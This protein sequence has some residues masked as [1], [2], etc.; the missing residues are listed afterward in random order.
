MKWEGLKR[1]KIFLSRK[2]KG[3]TKYLCNRRHFE[4][5][6]PFLDFCYSQTEYIEGK[7]W[8]CPTSHSWQAVRQRFESRLSDYITYDPILCTGITFLKNFYFTVAHSWQCCVSFRYIAKWFN[9]TY[10]LLVAQLVKKLPA[11]AGDMGLILGWEYPLEK[12]M[13]THYSI[14][15]WEIPWTEE[16]GG[17]QCMGSQES[18]MT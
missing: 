8:Y 10:V 12:E 6:N 9:Y 7:L 2:I 1:E 14:L 15:A 5:W 18:D 3:K 4:P 17:I 13:A 11:N 16:P